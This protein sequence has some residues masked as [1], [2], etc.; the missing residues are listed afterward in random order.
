MKTLVGETITFSSTIHHPSK[1]DI[2]IEAIVLKELT[3]SVICDVS[4]YDIYDYNQTVVNHKHYQILNT[5]KAKVKQKTKVSSDNQSVAKKEME[6]L[7]L[8]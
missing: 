3:N 8:F 1:K 5:P 6:Q 2:T 7:S 4:S